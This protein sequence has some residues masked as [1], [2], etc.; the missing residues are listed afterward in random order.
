MLRHAVPTIY[1]TREFAGAGGLASYGPQYRGRVV[2]RGHLHR[3]DSRGREPGRSAGPASHEDRA[4]DQNLKAARALDLNFL[5]SLIG[6]DDEVI[7][8]VT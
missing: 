2:P 7:E 3:P 6:R 1:S 4:G 8:L 5:L